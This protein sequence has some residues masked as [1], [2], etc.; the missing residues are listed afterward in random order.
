MARRYC[1]S[2]A[3]FALFVLTASASLALPPPG[4]IESVAGDAFRYAIDPTLPKAAKVYRDADGLDHPVVVV[5]DHKGFASKFVEDEVLVTNDPAEVAILVSKYHAKVVRQVLVQMWSAD[6]KPLGPAKTKP[7]TVLQIDASSSALRLEDEAKAIHMPGA[8]VFST[9]KSA[10]LAAIVLHERTAG[11]GVQLNFLAET[12]SGGYPTSSTEQADSNGVSDAYQWPEFDH[13]AWQYVIDKNPSFHP[14]VA[15]IDGGFWLNTQGVPCGYAVDAL[16]GPG[17]KAEGGSDLPQSMIEG[18]ATGSGFT[19]GPNPISCTNGSAC[20]WHG[21]MSA[22]VAVGALNNHTGA[23]GMGGPV[24]YPMLIKV[25]APFAD[26]SAAIE[27]A[28]QYG[29]HVISMSLGG[30]CNYWCQGNPFS[31]TD[32]ITPIEALQQGVPVIAAAGNGDS[33]GNGQDAGDVDFWPCTAT[34]FCVGALNP[35]SN[36]Y[37]VKTNGFTTTYSNYGNSVAFYAPT[38]IHAMPDG[39]TQGQQLTLHNGTSASTPYVAGVVALMRA[40]N[41]SLTP[42]QIFNDL[43]ANALPLQVVAYGGNQKGVAISPFNAVVAAG[44]T[45]LPQPHLIITQP[46]DKASV[47]ANVYQS[48]AFNA[49]VKDPA[50]ESWP[51]PYASGQSDNPV[52]W[53][54]SVDGA[55]GTGT[56]IAYTF[57]PTAKPGPRQI[58]AKVSDTL[59]MS[60]ANTITV[61]YEPQIGGPRVAI[62]YP[63]ANSSFPAGTIVV[64]GTG[65]SAVNLSYVPCNK[66]VW[67]G[68]IVSTGSSG[69]CTAQVTFSPGAQTLTLTATD[70][71]GKSSSTQEPLTITTPPPT[72]KVSID[73]PQMNAGYVNYP[74][75]NQPVPIG[76]HAFVLNA[77]A[78]AALTYTWSWYYTSSDP[79]TAIVIGTGQSQT[80]QSKACGVIAIQVVVTSP[81]IPASQSPTATT[82]VQIS[83]ESSQ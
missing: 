67:Q 14:I 48:V 10:R 35:Y 68:S 71:T 3:S 51:P 62:T 79:S 21:D 60:T 77:P 31:G 19:G 70:T 23:A 57:S 30:S 36:S 53:S 5:K 32:A 78:S 34:P 56:S 27:A 1:L 44:G 38:N 22:S 50:V 15:I 9:L 82:K 7:R 59:G 45:G 12:T 26:D 52:T 64:K 58:T 80:L 24:A 63:P 54:S 61:D 8:H 29:A 66:L 18:D 17:A 42:Q 46:A 25:G 69:V 47:G 40:I 72:A 2:L 74:V 11:H 13:R 16:C 83:C 49:E 55:M 33:N 4:A 41:P 76:L 6:H 75:Y 43:F 28:V 73:S 65:S 39:S 81:S 37:F 20:P